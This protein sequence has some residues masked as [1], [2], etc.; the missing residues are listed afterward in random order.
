MQAHQLKKQKNE[1]RRKRIGRGGKRGTYCGR[2]MKGQNA[3]TGSSRRLAILDLIKKIP[4]LRGVP[5]RRYK[6]LGMKQYKVIPQ[7]VNLDVLERKFKDGDVISPETLLEKKLVRRIKGRTPSVKILGRGELK[8]KLAFQGV[9][10]SGK[11]KKL[12]QL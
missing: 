9:E 6:K 4:K 8:K 2:G 5:A 1:K 12:G 3:R 11:V 7:V 10:M